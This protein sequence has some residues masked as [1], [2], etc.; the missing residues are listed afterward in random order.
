MLQA[1]ICRNADMLGLCN[2]ELQRPSVQ[3]RADQQVGVLLCA[4]LT[5]PRTYLL[6]TQVS[7][8]CQ[9]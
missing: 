6:L 4:Y 5:V 2:T 7:V 8:K 9:L 1:H 3:Q